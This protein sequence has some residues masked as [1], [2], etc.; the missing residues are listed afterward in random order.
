MGSSSSTKAITP[1]MISPKPATMRDQSSVKIPTTMST[2]PLMM[3]TTRS[4]TSATIS[5]TVVTTHVTTTTTIQA[6][7]H[8]HLLQQAHHQLQSCSTHFSTCWLTLFDT[9]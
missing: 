5:H 6:R 8:N 7:K 1:P 3:F 9:H 4:M 2:R